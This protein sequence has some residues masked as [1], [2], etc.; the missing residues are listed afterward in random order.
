MFKC[1]T[2]KAKDGEIAYLREMLRQAQDRIMA[3]SGDALARYQSSFSE[4]VAP[5]A[6]DTIKGKLESMEAITEQEKKDKTMAEQQINQ[7]MS[8][9]VTPITD[10]V[11]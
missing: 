11:I 2:C 8:G 10:E 1:K 6:L 5:T 4:P 7:L 3:L 9:D